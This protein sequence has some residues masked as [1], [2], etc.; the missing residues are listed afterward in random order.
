M[1]M[2][3]MDVLVV[4]LLMMAILFCWRLNGRIQNMKQVGQEFKPFIKNLSSYLTQI[5]GQIDKLREATDISHKTL[6]QQLPKGMRLKD[7]FD[8]IF[9]HGEK[10]AQRLDSVLEKAYRVE[11][12]LNEILYRSA[13]EPTQSFSKEVQNFAK[14]AYAHTPLEQAINKQMQPSSAHIPPSREEL[15]AYRATRPDSQDFESRAAQPALRYPEQTQ[16]PSSAYGNSSRL[17]DALA[18][19]IKD[20]R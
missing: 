13:K 19:R 3:V 16:S 14:E 15:H 4:A 10:L 20:L 11:R 8:V 9:D 5:T 2:L 18:A 17:S 1:S 7:D 12:Q 6:G